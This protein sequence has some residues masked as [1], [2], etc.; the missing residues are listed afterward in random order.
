MELNLKI[1]SE[2][3]QGARTGRPEVDRVCPACGQTDEGQTGEY[4]CPNCGLPTLWDA[5]M[6]DSS[7]KSNG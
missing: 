3:V 5:P 7:G 4:P 6:A 1:N 2:S